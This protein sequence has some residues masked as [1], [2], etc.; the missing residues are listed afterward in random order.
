LFS[1]AAFSNVEYCTL[2]VHTIYVQYGF[3]FQHLNLN[4]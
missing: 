4:C 1:Y 3:V 2:S